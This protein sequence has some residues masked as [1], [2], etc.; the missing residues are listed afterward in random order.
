M[1]AYRGRSSLVETLE[2]YLEELRHDV[3]RKTQLIEIDHEEQTN[4]LRAINLFD[5]ARVLADGMPIT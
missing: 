2:P 1:G 5:A 4:M 3:R